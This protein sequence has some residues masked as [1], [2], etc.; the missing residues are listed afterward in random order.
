MIHGFAHL[1]YAFAEMGMRSVMKIAQF[2]CGGWTIV[3]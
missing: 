1:L 3:G 2:A